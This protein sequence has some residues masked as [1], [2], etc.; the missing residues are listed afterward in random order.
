M[1]MKIVD[2]VREA[3]VGGG[4]VRKNAKTGRWYEVGDSIAREKVS[5]RFRDVIEKIDPT[6]YQKKP[7]VR[8]SRK[9]IRA[10]KEGKMKKKATAAAP[11]AVQKESSLS[12]CASVVSASDSS[13]SSSSTKSSASSDQSSVLPVSPLSSTQPQTTQTAADDEFVTPVPLLAFSSTAMFGVDGNLLSLD[14]NQLEGIFCT[15]KTGGADVIP[16]TGIEVYECQD[17]RHV[18]PN[19]CTNPTPCIA[20]SCCDTHLI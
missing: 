14:D 2:I 7:R 9:A 1:V 8:K 10:A 17:K 20:S 16:D 5:Q 4:F 12:D 13:T 6:K 11:A 3:S 19:H 15:S 18:L